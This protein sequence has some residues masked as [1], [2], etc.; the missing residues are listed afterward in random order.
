MTVK[1]FYNLMVEKGAENYELNLCNELECCNYPVT[2]ED[3]EIFDHN[4]EVII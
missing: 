2:E 4:K 1:E 3:I